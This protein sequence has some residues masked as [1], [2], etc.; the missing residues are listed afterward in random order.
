MPMPKSNGAARWA[1]DLIS[2]RQRHCDI[3]D[4]P[5]A[6]EFVHTVLERWVETKA[7]SANQNA[8]RTKVA[9]EFVKV[10]RTAFSRHLTEHETLLYQELW[11]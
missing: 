5:E 3:C 10:A 8:L 2:Y 9:E 11:K 1:D 4:H 7:K 6:K